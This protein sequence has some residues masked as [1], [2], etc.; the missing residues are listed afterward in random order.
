[1]KIVS[2]SQKRMLRVELYQNIREAVNK[3]GLSI[4]ATAS[5]FKVHRR[6]VRRALVS[7]IPPERKVA[8]KVRP[9][10]GA[11]EATVRGW[12]E[13]DLSVPR[14]QRHTATRIWQRLVDELGADVS[15][16][17]VRVMVR[18]LKAEILEPPAMAMVPQFHVPGETAEVDFGDVWVDLSGERTKVK[19]FAMRLS[20]SGKAFHEIYMGESQ[21]CFLDGHEKAFIAFGGI[22]RT[23][24]YDNLT[25]A[26][27][28]VLI[29]RDRLENERFIAFRSHYGFNASYCTPGIEGAHEKGGVEGEVKRARRRYMVPVP[30][31]ATL[32]EINSVLHLRVDTDDKTRHIEYRRDTVETAF[33]EERRALHPLIAESFGTAKILFAKVDAKSRVCVRQAFYSVPVSLIGRSVQ[34]ALSA[35]EVSISYK[36]REVAH[37]GQLIHRGASQLVLDHYLETFARKPGA[38]PHSVPLDQARRNGTFTKAHDAFLAEAIRLHGE[39]AAISEMV[40]VL[41]LAR[42][43]PKEAIVYGLSEALSMHMLQAD[44]VEIKAR[45]SLESPAEPLYGVPEATSDEVDLARY[46]V[47]LR[48]SA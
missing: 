30:K 9:K 47:L 12:L 46:N 22:P 44:V 33:A 45:S 5:E 2:R 7:G 37:H 32:A 28:K 26:V 27:V 14:K 21:E 13:D 43:L 18:E 8:P 48:T 3:Q 24:R 16:S 17:A 4:R 41:L 38:F 10:L 40:A 20:A 36:D 1:M 31:G 34:I 29:G 15:V 23:I 35:N 25:S 6:D 19:M 11:Y 42:R 39:Q